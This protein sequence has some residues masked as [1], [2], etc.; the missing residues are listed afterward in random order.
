MNNDPLYIVLS[1]MQTRW[2]SPE[3]TGAQKGGACAGEDGR[4][5]SAYFPIQAGGSIFKSGRAQLHLLHPHA[6]PHWRADCG[7]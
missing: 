3:N 2:A 7:A 4:K 5:R 1:G 6:V